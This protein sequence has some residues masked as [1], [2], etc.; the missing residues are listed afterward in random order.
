[1]ESILPPRLVA[2]SPPLKSDA[3]RPA[4]EAAERRLRLIIES[5]PAG[6]MLM[7]PSGPV[8]AAN[9]AWLSL[10]GLEDPIAIVGRSADSVIS[11]EGREQF[12]AF[13]EGVA[14]GEAG[15]LEYDAVCP[16]GSTRRLEMRAVPIPRADGTPLLLTASADVSDRGRLAAAGEEWRSRYGK[17]AI[18]HDRLK[19]AL[20][21]AEVSLAAEQARVAQ[22]LEERDEWRAA[23]AGILRGAKDTQEQAQALLD[24]SRALRLVAP[25]SS[26]PAAGQDDV[27]RTATGAASAGA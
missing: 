20:H 17:L 11:E 18:Q 7:D 22:L 16:D 5:A 15:A 4:P 24:R 21:A 9:R 8:V 3:V 14:R 26:D 1:M 27:P 13:V 23:L 6:L 25:G 19:G 10:L 2:P 12:A